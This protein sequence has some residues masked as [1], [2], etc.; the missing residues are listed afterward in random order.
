MN[1]S[2]RICVAGSSGLLGHAI[3]GQL[4]AAGYSNIIPCDLPAV[5][6]CDQRQ[7]E[8]FFEKEKPEYLFFLAAVAGGIQFKRTYPADML[9][10]NLQMI[11]NVM[12]AA[13][14]HGCHRMINV[15]SALLYPVEAKIPLKE[16]DATYVNLG[17]DDT[18]YALAKAAGMQ[19]AR[20]YNKQYGTRYLTVVPCNFFGEHAP[21]EGDKAG[22]VSAL[23]ARIHN[24]KIH[25][26]DH[27]E[28]W[29]TGNACRELLNS[30]D[31]AS[32]C[33]FLMDADT[34]H[35]LINIGRGCEF[36]I[37]EVAET[38]KKVVR[39][40]GDLLFDATKPEGRQHMQLDTSI[41]FGLGWRPSMDLERSI[42]NAY[43][44]YV[45]ILERMSK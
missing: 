1:Q 33:I 27:V 20:F 4:K 42:R 9:R 45:E 39:Y 21:F 23:I 43:D 24:A 44:W 25:H 26:I 19:L 17:L 37:R 14:R 35:D 12:D 7:T 29:G 34:E 11:T 22:V 40:E 2:S 3:C 38:I 15:C 31:V 28:V 6:L 13:Y 36:S 30:Q 41:L 32:A 10:K 8:A 16:A 18:P 5:D